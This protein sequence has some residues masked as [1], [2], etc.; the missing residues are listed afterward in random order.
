MHEWETARNWELYFLPGSTIFEL[1]Q[2]PV[3]SPD[4]QSEK[5]KMLNRDLNNKKIYER[6]GNLQVKEDGDE[7][8]SKRV[9]V[10]LD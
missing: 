7:K 4:K 1:Y 8:F 5:L 3:Q 6:K 9:F 2:N 10:L